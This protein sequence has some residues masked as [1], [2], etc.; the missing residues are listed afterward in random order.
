VFGVGVLTQAASL[1]TA[2]R[3]FGYVVI[4]ICLAGLTAVLTELRHPRRTPVTPVG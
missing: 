3:V 1:G 4:A 2:I